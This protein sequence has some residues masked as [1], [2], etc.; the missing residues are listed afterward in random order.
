MKNLAKSSGFLK[1]G[2]SKDENSIW[3]TN[4]YTLRKL[5]G[6]FGMALPLLL[7]IFLLID[8]GYYYPLHSISHYYFTRVASIFIIIISTLGIFLIVYKGKE[9]I[10]F[11]ISIISGIFA[12]LL[13][14]FPTD[15]LQNIFVDIDSKNSVIVTVLSESG[16]RELFHY[17]SAGIFLV[18]LAIMSIFLFTKSDKSPETRGKK[19]I[20][21]NR[22]FRTCGITILVAIS[23][24]L[25]GTLKIIPEEFY[26]QY[27]LTFWM[28][29]VAIESFGISW[30][31]KGNTFFKD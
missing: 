13:V 10:D 19:K 5:I 12:L 7:Y 15:N 29:V 21:R 22:I 2:Y 30:L 17:I 28:E 4:S 24:I 3:L 31:I 23:I 6:V 11:F 25:A 18:G 9:P 26:E 16:V 8:S 1:L 20:I 14:L 27:R